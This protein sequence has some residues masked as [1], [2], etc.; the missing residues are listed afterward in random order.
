ML[1]GKRKTRVLKLN[2][3]IV[4]S[5]EK[6]LDEYLLWKKAEGRS[7]R[8][9]R[10]YSYHVKLFFKRHP[11]ASLNDYINLK[12]C[13]T[14]YMS[15]DVKPA[16]YNNKLVYLKT[17][18]AWCVKESL[19]AENPLQDLKRRKADSRIVQVDVNVIKRL[20]DLPDKSTYSGLRDYALLLLQLDTGIRP[21]EALSLALEDINLHSLEVYIRAENAKTRI[22]RT[23]PIC[24][25]TAKA[26]HKLLNVRSVDWGKV[27]VFCSCEGNKLSGN[28]WYKRL[29]TYG[30]S[31]GVTSFPYQMRHTFAIEFLR[32]GGNSFA[33][34]KTLGHADLNMTKRYVALADSDIKEQHKKASPVTRLALH[35]NRMVKLKQKN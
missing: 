21:K 15:E 2:Q 32:N 31:I 12:A 6:A 10:D 22:A 18:F 17:F 1:K 16:Y 5:W 7:A 4:I 26:I 3:Q 24:P 20:L 28:G 8:T 14:G 35:A 9:I 34:Q 13:L 19:L 25:L 27:P 29:S 11:E 33:L 23:V 30:K